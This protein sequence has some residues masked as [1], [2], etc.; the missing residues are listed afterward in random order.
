MV[1]MLDRRP[2]RR[3]ALCPQAIIPEDAVKAKMLY[4][5]ATGDGEVDFDEV[6]VQRPNDN[7]ILV[8]LTNKDG[9]SVEIFL[10]RKTLRQVLDLKTLLSL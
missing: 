9:D 3:Y 2:R 4:D 6:A 10:D 8:K 7:V 5:L 1:R